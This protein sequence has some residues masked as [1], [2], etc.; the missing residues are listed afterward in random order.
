MS[1]AAFAKNAGDQPPAILA[2]AATESWSR[3]Y[4]LPNT[5]FLFWSKKMLAFRAA[6]A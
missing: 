2:N 1:V 4:H 6:A 5:F 3:L